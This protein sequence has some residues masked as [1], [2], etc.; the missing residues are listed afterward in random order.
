M[1]K[2]GISTGT[3]PNDG[4][5]DSLLDGAIKINSNFN[6]IYNYLGDGTNLTAIGGTW[7]TTTVGIHTLKN[8]G[9]GTTN[10]TS[11]LT[12][13]GN[14][15]ISGVSTLGNTIVGGATTQLVVNGDA[16]ITGI[17][18][19]G[20]SSI[21]LNGSSN[22]IN[23]GSGITINGS[24]GII[25]ATS[26]VINGTS[27]TGGGV[28]SITAGSG[29]S[30]DQSTGN[31]T[32]TAT[33][34]GGGSSQW[35]STGAG[36]HTTS[37]VGIGTTVP[38]SKLDVYGSSNF[39]TGASSVGIGTTAVN[40][41]AQN[42]NL[43]AGTILYNTPGAFFESIV[44]TFSVTSDSILFNSSFPVPFNVPT[45]SIASTSLLPAFSIGQNVDGT[46]EDHIGFT[47]DNIGGT[48]GVGGTARIFTSNGDLKIVTDYNGIATGSNITVG[49]EN[50]IFTDKLETQEHLRITSSG[51]GIGTTN[52]TSALT[53]TGDINATGVVTATS[54]V[55][56]GSGLTGV[57]GSGSGI[58]VLDDGSP[59]GTAGTID[60]GANLS[61]SAISAGV[62]TIT[63]STG[64]PSQWVSTAIGIHTLSNV[65][66]GTTNPTSALTV[67]GNTSLEIL[68]ISGV[69]TFV[70][71]LFAN[72][73]YVGDYDRIFFGNN[74]NF[75][76]GY[77]TG[78][79]ESLI[80]NQTSAPFAIDLGS[81]NASTLTVRTGFGN[82]LAYFS[83]TN[84]QLYESTNKKFETI[85]AGVTV[86]GTTF[87]NQL[88]VSGVTTTAGL[89]V[90]NIAD[91]NGS[92]A[93]LY[94]NNDQKFATKNDG[95]QVTGLNRI[96]SSTFGFGN[97]GIKIT[98]DS[99]DQAD[100]YHTSAGI[101]NIDN[102]RATG[103]SI[104]FRATDGSGNTT[105]QARITSSGVG[106]GTTNPTSK[107]TVRGGDISVGV[108]TAH[109][110]VLTSPNGTQ[111]RLIVSD[112]GALSTV[113][114]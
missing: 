32:I 29:I 48:A 73:I 50:I 63:A 28:T 13:G 105:E 109:G 38:S 42:I 100:I 94:F 77:D 8:V 113:A 88:S 59:I 68:N 55:G 12:V 81:N 111:Y 82:T 101:L 106:I 17:L 62:V 75:T 74:S 34:G 66:I 96:V 95:I 14:I 56:D 16:R 5:G 86:T 4:T 80:K 108:S 37:N 104:A 36:I 91:F 22:T 78:N 112:A 43:N 26:I 35:V 15:S 19:I 72:D 54:F 44:G 18:T 39:T 52:P 21:T 6:E 47:Y 23:V 60:F 99:T 65:G 114:V 57:I 53:V 33:G 98:T 84:V 61:V 1:A 102:Y 70:G 27:I 83:R 46:G 97:N 69:S 41:T 103:G 89:I 79:G 92:D 24:T 45:V 20:S 64:T 85:G 2:L 30:V 40:V 58:V 7:V 25:S 3:I 93:L 11:S 49:S 67:K 107:L 110:V 31:V 9:I 10:P 76:I 87:T 71:G 51:V 90:S